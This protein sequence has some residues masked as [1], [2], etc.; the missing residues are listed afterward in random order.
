MQWIDTSQ[1]LPDLKRLYWVSDGKDIALAR[2]NIKD[3]C[4]KF[5]Y[6]TEFFKPRLML[7]VIL[8]KLPAL[9]SEYD[10]QK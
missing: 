7:P 8:P 10:Q 3:M 1:E 5:L 9:L 2:W 6:M 4:W